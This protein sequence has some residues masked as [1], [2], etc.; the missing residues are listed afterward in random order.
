MNFNINNKLVFIERFQFLSYLKGS[1]VKN[2]VKDDF[3]ALCWNALLNMK[4]FELE[5][6]SDADMHLFIERGTAEFH[7]F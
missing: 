2:L 7:T 5:L 3:I 1:S 6:I 4:K